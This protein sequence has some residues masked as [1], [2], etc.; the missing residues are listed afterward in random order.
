MYATTY[1]MFMHVREMKVEMMVII[2]LPKTC[3]N[4]V[5]YQVLTTASMKTAGFWDIA[6]WSD[7][8]VDRRFS[9]AYGV[10]HQGDL[11]IEAVRTSETSVYLSETTRRCIP[12]GCQLH[13]VRM[14]K[15]NQ[16]V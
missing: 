7:V 11:I 9:R 2:Y 8:G 5:R 6:P 12:E 15:C 13:A 3:L 10:Y 14:L 4:N 16:N 1:K